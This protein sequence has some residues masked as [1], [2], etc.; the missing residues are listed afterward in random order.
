MATL[1]TYK[2]LTPM[3][4]QWFFHTTP[5]VASCTPKMT[6]SSSAENL[7]R[8]FPAENKF[9]A[10]F[11]ADG[12]DDEEGGSKCSGVE[13][14]LTSI[15]YSNGAIFRGQVSGFTET[16]SFDWFSGMQ[17]IGQY[18]HD[19]RNGFGELVWPDGS[20][21]EGGFKDD[22]REGKGI[23]YWDTGEVRKIITR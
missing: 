14:L 23:H 9:R 13:P 4:H 19:R 17:Y 1:F 18:R 15:Q 11:D 22:L 5:G 7:P 10:S 12:N 20:R 3:V 2:N 6:T 16:G 8:V 21:Y